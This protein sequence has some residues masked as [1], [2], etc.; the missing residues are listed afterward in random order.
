MVTAIGTERLIL[1]QW[2][3]DDAPAALA[4][5]GAEAVS[6]WLPSV[7]HIGD[8]AEMRSSIQRWLIHDAYTPAP[9]GHWAIECRAE[10]KV[11]GGLA[12]AYV[13]KRGGNLTIRWELAPAEWG[14]GYAAEAT[15]A[16]VHWAMHV[17]GVVEVY[18]LVHPQN[19]RATATAERVGMEPV[20][21]LGSHLR[22]YRARDGLLGSPEPLDWRTQ[23]TR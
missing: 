13:P 16:L 15:D 22:V 14:R 8:Q 2:S 3:K 20:R 5:Y 9:A 19:T 4:I 17:V 12:L 7:G 23:G 21:D 10:G 11:I 18:A 6:Q 1:R